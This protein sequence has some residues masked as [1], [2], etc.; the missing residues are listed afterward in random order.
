M[1]CIVQHGFFEV[2]LST[3]F[4]PTPTKEVPHN[5]HFVLIDLSIFVSVN[6]ITQQV[7]D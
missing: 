1:K 3:N 2:S 7:S 4:I 5:Q 6:P